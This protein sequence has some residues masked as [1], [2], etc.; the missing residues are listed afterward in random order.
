MVQGRVLCEKNLT[1]NSFPPFAFRFCSTV[2]VCSSSG[3]QSPEL[4][5]AAAASAPD[6]SCMTIAAGGVSLS[7]CAPTLEMQSAYLFGLNRLLSGQGRDISVDESADATPASAKHVERRRFSVAVGGGPSAA[8]S[9][10]ASGGRSSMSLLSPPTSVSERR[11]SAPADANILAMIC[12]APFWLYTAS[13]DT[14][15]VSRK[16]C[17]L[18]YEQTGASV[19]TIH[20]CDVHIQP[21]VAHS[22]HSLPL[23]SL[24]DIYNLHQSALFQSDAGVVEG[25]VAARC[26][27]LISPTVELN[28]EAIDDGVVEQWLAGL[29]LLLTGS[30]RRVEEE[31]ADV[32]PASAAAMLGSPTNAA[33]V[34]PD[35][36][37][38][39]LSVLPA[40]PGG[41]PMHGGSGGIG[42]GLSSDPSSRRGSLLSLST[43]D[44]LSLLKKGQSFKRF[45]WD[46]WTKSVSTWDIFLYYREARDHMGSGAIHWTEQDPPIDTADL[47]P[48]SEHTLK[49]VE[50]NE[51]CL[52]VTVA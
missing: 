13:L 16:R 50:I 20:W 41:C 45:M 49:I 34:N 7:V 29:R 8:S 47:D 44:T 15:L 12:G 19:G 46:G 32:Q 6:S 28:V 26:L 10:R 48:D 38:R 9:S 42:G 17:T 4:Q 24:S 27:T 21:R 11:H 25:S 40:L 5:S 18:W 36:K 14:G 43:F 33:F 35:A 22:N 37:L 52:S 30:G 1:Q 31:E 2:R 23:A 3:K 39:R 51:I